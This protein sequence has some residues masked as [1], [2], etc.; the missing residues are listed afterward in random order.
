[1]ATVASGAADFG[2]TGDRIPNPLPPGIGVEHGYELE[3]L[4]ITSLKHPLAKQRAVRPAD[5]KRYPVLS[6]RHSLADLPDSAARFDREGIFGGPA[7][8]VEPFLAT[9]L[10]RYVELNLGIALVM[11]LPQKRSKQALHERSMSRYFG[12]GKVHF[13]FRL[14]GST[15]E[16]ARSFAE[17]IRKCNLT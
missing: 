7:P 12:R 13:A 8:C 2:L 15:E 17:T 14:G 5:L 6:S 9:T 3:T 1:M 10:R 16:H 4:L 11:G